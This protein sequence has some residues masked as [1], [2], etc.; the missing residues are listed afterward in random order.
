M[1]SLKDFFVPNLSQCLSPQLYRVAE[2]FFR[3]SFDSFSFHGFS[4]DSS[5]QQSSLHAEGVSTVCNV[6]GIICPSTPYTV[7]AVESGVFDAFKE[8]T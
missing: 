4:A 5:R 3:S 7:A 2:Y 1:I 6:A 8:L